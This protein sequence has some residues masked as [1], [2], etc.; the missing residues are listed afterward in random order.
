VECIAYLSQTNVLTDGNTE[1]IIP[2]AQI[3]LP[4]HLAD[5]EC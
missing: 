1:V 3:A 2:P 4:L 5:K